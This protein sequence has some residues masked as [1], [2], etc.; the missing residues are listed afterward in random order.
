[1]PRFMPHEPEL[2]DS[3]I[4]VCQCFMQVTKST[5]QNDNVFFVYL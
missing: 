5:T 3:K 1:M 2:R 4:A